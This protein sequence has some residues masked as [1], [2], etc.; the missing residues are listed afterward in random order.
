MFNPDDSGSGSGK[1]E[2]ALEDVM[3]I[4]HEAHVKH[5]VARPFRNKDRT[6]SDGICFCC[7]DCC[8]Y[9]LDPNEKCDKGELVTE[10]DFDVCNHC[11]VC[12]D[13]CYFEA[14][15]VNGG[16][17]KEARDLCYGCGLCLNVCPEDCIKMV[18]RG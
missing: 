16:E 11:G 13:V 3:E 2:V 5:L 12:A 6:D 9:F 10:T 8:G 7:D 14:R 1:K 15:T 17:L 18:L 4:L